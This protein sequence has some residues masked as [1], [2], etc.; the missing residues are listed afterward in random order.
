MPISRDD[1]Y[2]IAMALLAVCDD[3]GH[4]HIAQLAFAKAMDATAIPWS[5][6]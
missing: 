6:R 1:T 3:E 4:K 2:T 5:N